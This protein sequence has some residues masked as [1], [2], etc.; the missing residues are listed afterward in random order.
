MP[1]VAIRIPQLG[2]GL[3]ESLVIELFKNAGD[4]VKRD[5]PLYAMETDKGTMDI[6]SPYDGVLTEWLVEEGTVHKIGAAIAHMEVADGVE[7]MAAGHGPPEPSAATPATATPAA[8]PAAAAVPSLVKGAGTLLGGGTLAA[9]ATAAVIGTGAIAVP[10][11]VAT[12]KANVHGRGLGA[13]GGSGAPTYAGETGRVFGAQEEAMGER[14]GGGGRVRGG[15][16]A[17]GGG[18]AG[19][20]KIEG[21][22]E[23]QTNI[24]NFGRATAELLAAA[25]QVATLG[26]GMS[27]A[28]VGSDPSQ[29]RGPL[30]YRTGYE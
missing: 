5:E 28:N 29:P 7:E 21:N 30:S 9:L 12:G 2:E 16:G 11:S 23:F 8:A 1:T 22:D 17:G 20:P 15:G 6:E 4:Q 18:A 19:P 10:L 26:G 25:R 3:Q 13:A 14:G 27:P 24:A